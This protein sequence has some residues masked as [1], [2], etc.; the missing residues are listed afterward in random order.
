MGYTRKD[1]H[2]LEL[3]DLK[4]LCSYC[5]AEKWVANFETNDFANQ[6]SQI[7]KATYT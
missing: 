6:N 4:F 1:V 7:H 5:L 2:C 3:N